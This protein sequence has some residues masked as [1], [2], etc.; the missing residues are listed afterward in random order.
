MKIKIKETGEIKELLFI[1][2]TGGEAITIDVVEACSEVLNIIDSK[3]YDR[4][5]GLFECD[6]KAYE[7]AK[8]V[9]LNA[10]QFFHEEQ[11]EMAKKE[12]QN[13]T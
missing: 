8:R 2:R 1:D 12:Q 10:E 3:E 6:K 9:V 11:E 13:E 4:E 5:T 7:E